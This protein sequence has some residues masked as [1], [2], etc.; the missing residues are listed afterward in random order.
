MAEIK[1][2]WRE[3]YG[4]ENPTHNRQF[5]EMCTLTSTIWMTEIEVWTP[6]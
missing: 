6:L 1:A 4:R 5:L 2:L 3:L